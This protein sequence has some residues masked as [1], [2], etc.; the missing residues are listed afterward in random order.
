MRRS[1][2]KGHFFEIFSYL[3]PSS[4]SSFFFCCCSLKKREQVVIW[5]AAFVCDERD[6][7]G[8]EEALRGRTEEGK[9]EDEE[10]LFR[11][12]L[13]IVILILFFFNE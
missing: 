5:S 8:R 10:M 3:H 7:R 1:A 12:C 11:L 2:T 6:D 4:S 9:W 13:E